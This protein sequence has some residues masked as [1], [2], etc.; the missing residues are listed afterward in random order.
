ME[1]MIGGSAYHIITINYE[2]EKCRLH[3]IKF[4]RIKVMGKELNYVTMKER[5]TLIHNIV[6]SF[7]EHRSVSIADIT[8]GKV[9]PHQELMDLFDFKTLGMKSKVYVAV[10]NA[11]T[12]KMLS[13]NP[14]FTDCSE[15]I[16]EFVESSVTNYVLWIQKRSKQG[17]ITWEELK[18]MLHSI[19]MEASSF[20]VRVQHFGKAYYQLY[21][22]YLEDKGDIITLYNADWDEDCEKSDEGTVIDTAS[23]VSISNKDI[24]EIQIGYA[25]LVYECGLRDVTITYKNGETVFLRFSEDI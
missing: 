18:K 8:D 24:K 4:W 16:V 12:E 7:V 2:L 14:D 25:D 6:M 20:G 15:E 9:D 13:V 5:H 22:N 17:V 3:T 11:L 10:K 23:Y 1:V 21:F 19:N